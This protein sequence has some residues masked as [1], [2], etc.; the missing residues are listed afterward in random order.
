MEVFKEF[1]ESSTIHGLVYIST[2]KSRLLRLL[3]TAIVLTAFSVALKLIS[4]SYI[5]WSEDPVST[6]VSTHPIEKLAFPNVT[7]CPPKG[8]NTALN[9]DLMK[10][11]NISLSNATRKDLVD[12][13]KNALLNDSY[14]DFNKLMV[15][16]AN[17][18]N[19]RKMYN[20]LQSLPQPH[21]KDGFE[22]RMW[23][24]SGNISTPWFGNKEGNNF[25]WDPIFYRTDHTYHY[26]LDMSTVKA[27]SIEDGA[28][29]VVNLDVDTRTVDGWEEWVEVRHHH[30]DFHH[31][32]HHHHHI[33]HLHDHPGEQWRYEDIPAL[34]EQQGHFLGGGEE[35]LPEGARRPPCHNHVRGGT[36]GRSPGP[37]NVR[38]R[39]VGCN[40]A[41]FSLVFFQ[42]VS[43]T[44]I[45]HSLGLEG[46]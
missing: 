7:V 11:K 21:G 3:W 25:T 20:K 12:E 39:W 30:H 22:V 9:Y 14:I 16:V 27:A 41:H 45:R 18:H 37:P 4:N 13:A 34:Q 15:A 33:H 32:C 40:N 8:F 24:P 36:V 6:S 42:K 19:L 29:F 31:K 5:D 2:S 43:P 35:A 38:C 28:V 10:T 1:L 17:P 46:R 26:V 23:S 44:Q